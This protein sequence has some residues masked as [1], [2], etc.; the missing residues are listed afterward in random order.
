MI[1]GPDA[2]IDGLYRAMHD[3]MYRIAYRSLGDRERSEELV[4]DV[5]VL[6]LF[7]TRMLAAHPNPK[8][9][10]VVTL[11]NHVWNELRKK[12]YAVEVPFDGVPVPAGDGR[13]NFE[14]LLPSRLPPEDRQVL[15]WRFDQQLSYREISLRLGISEPGCRSRVSRALER[16]RRLMKEEE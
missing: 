14:D 4:Q 13:E 9:W 5:F 1:D 15:I 7:N 10:L 12:A 6:A 2:F 8:G 11:K 16:C 3:V